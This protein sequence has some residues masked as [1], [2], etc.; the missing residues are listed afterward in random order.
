M[1]D[2]NSSQITTSSPAITNEE[3]T[4]I[5]TP[6]P[7]LS[8]SQAE[9]IMQI[10]L[11]NSSTT[12]QQTS[13]II[14]PN[15]TVK[16][17]PVELKDDPMEF[18][19][20]TNFIKR[21]KIVDLDEVNRKYYSAFKDGYSKYSVAFIIQAAIVGFQSVNLASLT[22]VTNSGYEV[23][24]GEA[25]DMSIFKIGN[26]LGKEDVSMRRVCE[27]SADI[28]REYIENRPVIA[29]NPKF[30]NLPRELR[31]IGSHYAVRTPE[32]ARVYIRSGVDEAPKLAKFFAARGIIN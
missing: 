1:S 16:P 5:I 8:G 27:G 11:S 12:S 17:I 18:V 7:S 19:M 4:E 30:L 14:P 26:Q 29:L 10:A 3:K 24:L 21:S 23:S 25:I 28:I 31:F 13:S 22:I 9:L 2:T 6:L 15:I 32:E 20:N